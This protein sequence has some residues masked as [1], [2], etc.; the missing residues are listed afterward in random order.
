MQDKRGVVQF[1]S[2]KIEDLMFRTTLD[3]KSMEGD[4]IVNLSIADADDIVDVLEF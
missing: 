3:L 1:T 4:I 2:S